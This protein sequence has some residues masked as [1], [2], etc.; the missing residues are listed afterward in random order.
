[1]RDLNSAP[2]KGVPRAGPRGS[3][4]RKSEGL[5][6]LVL[7]LPEWLES[8]GP[9]VC[10]ATCWSLLHSQFIRSQGHSLSVLCQGHGVA[11][12]A[13]KLPVPERLS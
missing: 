7:P 11:D 12:P 13:N 2:S 9:R 8:P 10:G 1:M 3:P 6:D 4:R 5:R